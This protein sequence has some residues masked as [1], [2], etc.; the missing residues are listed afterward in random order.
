MAMLSTVNIAA[1]AG[2]L[3]NSDLLVAVPALVAISLSLYNQGVSKF[4]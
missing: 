1:A 3:D 2:H 4:G